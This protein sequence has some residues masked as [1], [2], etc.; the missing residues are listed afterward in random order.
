MGK[1]QVKSRWY[2][3]IVFLLIACLYNCDLA[4]YTI[5]KNSATRC[6]CHYVQLHVDRPSQTRLDTISIFG[7][8]GLMNMDLSPCFWNLIYTAFTY[9]TTISIWSMHTQRF[10]VDTQWVEDHS[11]DSNVRIAEVDYD[12]K[13]YY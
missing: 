4:F 11:K 1:L 13:A 10:L 9:I 5:R 7:D 8:C 12:L 6:C 3:R 2:E